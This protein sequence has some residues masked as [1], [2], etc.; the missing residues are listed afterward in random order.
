[1]EKKRSDNKV[2]VLVTTQYRGVFFGY[3][4]PKI[5]TDTTMVLT[6]ARMVIYWSAECRGVLGLAANGPTKKCKIT[7]PVQRFHVSGVTSVLE[8]T[9]SAAKE[10]ENGYWK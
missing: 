9:A 2:P 3:G 10:F 8:V 1:M 7:P 4:N 5:P 6:N